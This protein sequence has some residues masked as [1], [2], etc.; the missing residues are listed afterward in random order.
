MGHLL[1][2]TSCA[3]RPS[4]NQQALRVAPLRTKNQYKS[5]CLLSDVYGI[6][7]RGALVEQVSCLGCFETFKQILITSEFQLMVLCGTTSKVFYFL[8][9]SKSHGR[10]IKCPSFK[11]QT[12]IIRQHP[13]QLQYENN[14]LCQKLLQAVS[15][16]ET[17]EKR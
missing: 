9:V 11:K 15:D 8:K 5:H 17:V 16:I 2:L 12:T 13:G 6:C 3:I 4:R 7:W 10:C 14:H 1:H